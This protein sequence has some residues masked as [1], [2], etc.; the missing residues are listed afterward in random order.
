MKQFLR[1]ATGLLF[2]FAGIHSSAQSF[3]PTNEAQ[4]FNVFVQNNVTAQA[5]DTHGPV[6]MGGNLI[7]NG[8]TIFTMNTSGKYPTGVLN[9]ND[10]YGMVIGNAVNYTGGNQ[11]QVNQ[12]YLRIGNP[13]GSAI[14]Y[15]DNNNTPGSNLKLTAASASY[16]SNPSVVLQRPQAIGTAT[17]SNGLNFNAAFAAFANTAGKINNWSG[18]SNT[19]FN[20]ITIPNVSNP[21]IALV[22]NKINYINLTATQLSDLNNLGSIIFDNAPAINRPL[23]VN[24]IASGNYTWTPPNVGS[25]SESDGAFVIWNFYGTTSLTIAGSNGIYGTVFSPSADI[26]KNNPNNLNGQVIGKSLLIGPGEIHYHPFTTSLPD[27]PEDVTLPIRGIALSAELRN[28]DATVKWT[29]YEET[30]IAG[31]DVERSIDGTSY[32]KIGSVASNVNSSIANYSFKDANLTTAAKVV[33]YR[34]RINELDGSSYY[35]KITAIKLSASVAISVWPN[36]VTDHLSISYNAAANQQITVKLLN[37]AGQTLLTSNY[38]LTKGLNQLTVNN[39]EKLEKGIYIL[40]ITDGN[41]LLS[42][43]KI[44]K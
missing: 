19:A 36:P 31:Y 42:A 9:N 16:S 29:V 20:K 8:S 2:V 24:V 33:Y 18:S 32:T 30:N 13:A 3:N 22:D 40:Q 14:W 28:N 7:L 6:A 43:E 41:N 11:S 38:S 34:I 21:H 39:L 27:P 5:G 4:G 37:V 1:T 25:V 35:S 17:L 44:I 15:L 23:V 26:Y 10:N 12:G